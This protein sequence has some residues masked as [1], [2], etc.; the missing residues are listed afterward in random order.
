MYK[1]Q[2]KTIGF[3]IVGTIGAEVAV[4]GQR[5]GSEYRQISFRSGRVF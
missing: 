4:I 5:F 2:Q 1:I 3:F